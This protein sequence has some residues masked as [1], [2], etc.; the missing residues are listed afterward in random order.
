[1][2]RSTSCT[3]EEN[4]AI[5]QDGCDGI[6]TITGNFQGPGKIAGVWYAKVK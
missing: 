3:G 4:T 1:M 6:A 2:L 5:I